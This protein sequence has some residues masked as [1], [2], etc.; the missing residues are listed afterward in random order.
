MD[1]NHLKFVSIPDAMEEIKTTLLMQS[2]FLKREELEPILRQL[3][4]FQILKW[5]NSSVSNASI[6]VL[7]Y[8]THIRPPCPRPTKNDGN[9]SNG[10]ISWSGSDLLRAWMKFGLAPGPVNM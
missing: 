6:A 8:Q 2:D 10:S 4:D 1:T 5:K 3:E 9:A 7:I